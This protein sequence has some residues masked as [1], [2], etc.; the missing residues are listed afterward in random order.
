MI[1]IGHTKMCSRVFSKEQRYRIVA[2]FLMGMIVIVTII[3]G[4]Q[5]LSLHKEDVFYPSKGLS[6]KKR[7][8]EYNPALRETPGDT[9][10]YLFQGTTD[11]VHILILGGTH[12][13]EPAGFLTAVVL[14]ENIAVAKG[15]I[16]IIP[17]ANRSGFTHNDPFEGDPQRFHVDTSGGMRS[18][19]FGS[20]LTNPVHQWPDSTLFTNTA[21]QK[22]SGA[23]ARNLNRNYPGKKRGHLT[24]MVAYGIIQLMEQEKID[25]A[26]DLHEA[27]PEYPIVNAMV[28]HENSAELAAI[29][30]LNLQLEGVNL[31]LES[32]PP[33]LR[34]LS[35]REWGDHTQAKAVLLETA[36]CSHGRLKG[37]PSARLVVEGK[38]K[39][40]LKAASL[41]RLFVSYDPDGI[42]LRKRVYRHLVSVKALALALQEMHPEKSL[43]FIHYPNTSIILEQGLGAQLRPP[44]K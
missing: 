12:P 3:T 37:R 21:G 32:S 30:S 6:T 8:S 38:D 2:A 34:G 18:F 43:V 14:L 9:T 11:G 23:E 17:Q 40:Y 25:L 36:N 44:A 42:P 1:R 19:R 35:H 10:V 26:I 41:G 31:S 16:F 13:K 39:N 29:S 33:N 27:A 15:K 7:L 22:L 5:F 20:R 4:R 28:F 24:E